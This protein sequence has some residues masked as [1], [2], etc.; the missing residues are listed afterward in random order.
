MPQYAQGAGAG[1]VIFDSVASSAQNNLGT[2]V[3]EALDSISNRAA[4]GGQVDRTLY[5]DSLNSLAAQNGVSRTGW[6]MTTTE[7]MQQPE[8]KGIVWAANP[9]DVTWNMSQRATH[10]KNLFGTVMH[11]WPDNFRN[12][13]FDEF[14]LTMSLQSGSLLPVRMSNQGEYVTAPGLNNFYEFMNLV[15]APKITNDGRVNMVT[16]IYRSNLFPQLT[17]LGMFDPAGIRFTDTSQSP[18]QVNAWSVD[19]VVYD[20][21]P[22]LSSNQPLGNNNSNQLSNPALLDAWLNVR[23]RGVPM[24]R[25]TNNQAGGGTPFDLGRVL[26]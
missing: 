23:L 20:T 1:N 19:F 16:I 10:V 13:F 11:V 12:T 15:D 3:G 24:N 17:L 22:K 8:Q 25:P 21:A 4:T 7:W 2:Q 14:R 26:G 9:S 6:L 18:N 5:S